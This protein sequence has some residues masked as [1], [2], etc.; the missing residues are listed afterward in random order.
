MTHHLTAWFFTSDILSSTS[1]S[2]IRRTLLSIGSSPWKEFWSNLISV[3]RSLSPMNLARILAPKHRD[4]DASCAHR[5]SWSGDCICNEAE[6]FVI[7]IYWSNYHLFDETV[8][9]IYLSHFERR[10]RI[11]VK[12]DCMR[13][14]GAGVPMSTR[15]PTKCGLAYWFRRTDSQPDSQKLVHEALK[16]KVQSYIRCRITF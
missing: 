10:W 14:V 16:L 7:R 13:A 4:R 6:Y 9:E 12:K 1:D 5:K 8:H 15:D 3:I 2:T 11:Y